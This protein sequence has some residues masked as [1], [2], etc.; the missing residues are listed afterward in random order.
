MQL[1]SLGG[2]DIMVAPLAFGGNV[3]GWTLDER[4]SFAMLDA[5]TDAGFNLIDTADTYSRWVPGHRGGESETILGR[6]MKARGNRSRVVIATKVGGDMGQGHKDLSA[7]YITTE[8]EQSL[9]RLQTDYV[10]LYQAHYDDPDTPV[11]ET[12]ETF[13]RLARAGKLRIIGASNFTPE[14]LEASLDASDRHGYPAYRTLQPLYN[15][16]DREPFEKRLE[17]LCR[18]RGLG[19]LSYY[20]LASGFLSGKYRGEEDKSKSPRGAGMDKYFNERGF[21][22]LDALD[23][24]AEGAGV[25]PA[26]AALAWLLSR[27]SVTAPVVSATSPAQLEALVRAAELT[28]DQDA[29]QLLDE[30]SA[31]S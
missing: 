8:L 29:L 22:I 31:W 13:D 17:P 5:F 10:D 19:V 3:F 20:S 21:R 16:Y 12:L 15:L 9:R 23:R 4:S 6:W 27:P 7:T 11:E 25:H 2:S 24:V 14:R 18:E 28:L 1:R 30:A 26:T